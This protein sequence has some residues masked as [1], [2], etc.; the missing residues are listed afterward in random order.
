M[1]SFS[2]LAKRNWSIEDTNVSASIAVKT[3][4][5]MNQIKAVPSSELHLLNDYSKSF[6]LKFVSSQLKPKQIAFGYAVLI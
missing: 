3:V 2:T 6:S 4:S 5:A 1:K